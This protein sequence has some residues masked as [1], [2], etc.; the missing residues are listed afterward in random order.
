MGRCTKKFIEEAV[1]LTGC[2]AGIVRRALLGILVVFPKI[3][4]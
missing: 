2:A 4:M 3:I 1:V